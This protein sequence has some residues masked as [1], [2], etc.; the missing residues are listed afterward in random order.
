[1]DDKYWFKRISLISQIFLLCFIF[2]NFVFSADWP[3]FRGPNRDGIS[4]ERGLLKKWPENGP[5]LIWSFEELGA[6]FSSPSISNG[7]VYITARVNKKETIFAFD[8]SGNLKWQT[9]YGSNWKGSYPEVRTSATIDGNNLFVHSGSGEVVCL[10]AAT[11]KIKW[12]VQTIEQFNGEYDRWG[13]AESPLIV[14][15]LVVATPG[16]QDASIVALDKNTGKKIWTSKGL[17][18]KSSY[19][20]PI[21]V[22]FDGKKII[23]TMLENSFVGVDAIS[24]RVLWRDGFNGY[25]DD[26]KAINPVSP[27]YHD[28]FI[29][30]SSGYD[31]GG[32]MYKLLDDGAK[33]SREWVDETLDI[34]HGGAV[35]V[36]GYIYGTNWKDNRNGNWVCLEWKTGKIMYEKEWI[37]K[38]SIIYADGMLYCYEEKNGNMALVSANPNEFKIINSFEVPLG[39]KQHWAH[40][41]ISDGR[42]YIRHGHALMVYDINTN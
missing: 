36:D 27:I 34:H 12:K 38:G 24:G 18:E 21:L 37:T 40:P 2:D 13:I 11:G 1:M 7:V 9:T 33:I 4:S 31:D 32:A 3:Q 26:P 28:G 15:N 29:Y 6:G 14:D 30:T 16:G 23:A 25:Q 22:E 19:C 10:H 41:A 39:S 5:K 35:F 8:I 17:S 42:L 20:S